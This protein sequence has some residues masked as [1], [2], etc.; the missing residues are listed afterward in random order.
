MVAFGSLYGN[1]QVFGAVSVDPK[2]LS[3]EF[4][5]ALEYREMESEFIHGVDTYHYE[6]TASR[7]VT[8]KMLGDL[9]ELLIAQLP[10]D[11]KS[12]MDEAIGA[13]DI[14]SFEVWIGKNDQNLYQFKFILNVPLSKVLGLNDSGIAGNEVNLNWM[15]TF[16]D[17]GVENNIAMPTDSIKV[18]DFVKNIKDTKIKNIISIFKPETT[19]FKN[20]IGSYGLRSNPMGSCTNPNPGSL[21]SPQ[22]HAKGADTAISA[23]SNSMISLLTATNGAGSCY[24]TSGAWALSAPLFTLKTNNSPADIQSTPVFYCTDSSGIITTLSTAITG[25]ACK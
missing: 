6:M 1:A 10:P 23:I 17:V 8:K 2:S 21:F 3:K 15:T 9:A 4:V 13:S 22:G 7:P 5:V 14:N 11:Q 24:S 16:Y 12:N 25:P 20:A 18:E 19:L